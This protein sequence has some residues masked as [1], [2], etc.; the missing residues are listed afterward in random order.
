[1]KSATLA[2]ASL[3]RTR[4]AARLA[5]AGLPLGV[6]TPEI[7]PRRPVLECREFL[8]IFDRGI[9]GCSFC[10]VAVGAGVVGVFRIANFSANADPIMHAGEPGFVGRC[11]KCW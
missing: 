4:P 11:R 3:N 8:P 2:R 7:G 6:G 5:A 1:M 9:E 10:S